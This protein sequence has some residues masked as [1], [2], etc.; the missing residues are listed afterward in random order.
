MKR[1]T[2]WMLAL[3][4]LLMAFGCQSNEPQQEEENQQEIAEDQQ[5]HQELQIDY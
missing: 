5:E 2:A 4:M 3:L 1:F